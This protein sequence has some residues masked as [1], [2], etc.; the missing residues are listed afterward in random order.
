M[1]DRFGLADFYRIDG[2]L[3]GSLG[4]PVPFNLHSMHYVTFRLYP[5]LVPIGSSEA[6]LAYSEAEGMHQIALRLWDVNR[7]SG[8]RVLV[9]RMSRAS[10]VG[11]AAVRN[12]RVPLAATAYR[13]QVGHFAESEIS[14]LNLAWKGVRQGRRSPWAIPVLNPSAVTVRTGDGSVLRLPECRPDAS[15]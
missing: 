11:P 15:L 1:V 8:E 6:N 5:D 7:D 9:S 4:A 10:S 3:R 2:P 13:I 14:N 12:V